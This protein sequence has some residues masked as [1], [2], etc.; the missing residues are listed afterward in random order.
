MENKAKLIV[1]EIMANLEERSGFDF[2]VSTWDDS[3]DNVVEELI[4]ITKD[5]LNPDVEDSGEMYYYEIHLNAEGYSMWLGIKHEGELNDNE[6]F[7]YACEIGEIEEDMEE[8]L[9]YITKLS[10]EQ[11]RDAGYNN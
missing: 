4:D 10:F 7:K 5:I 2:M 3:Y 8:D 6:V 9:K 1:E 11:Y